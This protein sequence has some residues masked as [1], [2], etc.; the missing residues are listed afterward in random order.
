MA[1]LPGD[2]TALDGD[3]DLSIQLLGAF[4]V[5]VGP[6]TVVESE[7]RLRKAKSL[8]KLLALAPGQQLHR[9]EL[10]EALW[11]E[12]DPDSA[13]NNLHKAVYTVRRALEPNLPPATPSRYLHVRGDTLTLHPPGALSIDVAAFEQAAAEAVRRGD[14]GAFDAALRFY[15]GD[16]LPEDRYEDW[17]AGRREDLR[18]RHLALLLELARLREAQRETAAASEALRRVVTQEPAHEEAHLALMGVYARAGQRHQALRQYQQLQ[19]TLRSELDV[20]PSP[21]SQRLYQDILAGRLAPEVS[22]HDA[23]IPPLARRKA[24]VES[25]AVLI[26]RER[27]IAGVT[28]LLRRPDV[29]LLT[30]TGPGGVGKTGLAAHV[31]AKLQDDAPDGVYVVSLAA[32]ADPDLVPAAIGAALAV[33]EQGERTIAER[34]R[35]TLTTRRLILVLDNFEHLLPA[36][37]YIAELLEAAPGL[38]VLVTSRIP[39]RLRAEREYPVAPLG[40]PHQALLPGLEHL[41]QVHAIRLFVERAQAIKPDFVLD[42]ES[43]LAVAEICRRLDGLPL[44]IE[45][46]AARVRL[47]SPQ[48]MLARL[49]QRLPLLTGGARDSPQ[50]QRSLRDAI[51]WSYDLLSDADRRLFRRLAVFAGGTSLQSAEVVTDLD[52]DLD[53]FAGLDRLVEQN[54]LRQIAGTGDDLRLGMLETIREFGLEQLEAAGEGPATRTCHAQ[55]ML[56]LYAA[57]ETHLLARQFG[58]WHRWLQLLEM[59]HD[60]LRA[61]LTWLASCG[62]TETGL[63]VAGTASLFWYLSGHWR[64][65]LGWLERLLAGDGQAHPGARARALVG[66]GILAH[67]VGD[68]A[69]SLPA[70]EEALALSRQH[71]NWFDKGYALFWLGVVA[72]NRGDYPQA[73][74]WLQE[75]LQFGRAG[76]DPYAIAWVSHHLGAVAFG[77]GE[78]E[79]ARRLWSEALAGFRALGAPWAIAVTLGALGLLATVENEFGPA[80]AQL[81][82]ALA[83]Y[84]GLD[85]LPDLAGCLANLAALALRL[86]QPAAATRVLSAAEAL[87]EVLGDTFWQPWRTVHE[88][89]KA[90]LAADLERDAFTLAW[91]AGSALTRE[92]ALAEARAILDLPSTGALEARAQRSPS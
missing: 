81:A 12:M 65:G 88:Q 74:T 39:L 14:A 17:A 77:R 87:N 23:P 91:Q 41:M 59:E 70:L 21:A 61:A 42:H 5:A 62:D 28:A 24:R 51:A 20:D 15:A 40:L 6:R 71:G 1:E 52:G 7:W 16:L 38:Q 8:V 66:L 35:D 44:A 2:E 84:D 76:G 31:A 46:A 22:E 68:D 75:S 86:D 37:L 18:A 78:L 30:L 25:G 90:A 33:R 85:A 10:L 43:A 27:E 67:R 58:S 19:E 36:A 54:L 57:G 11:P 47:L 50:R 49:E 63:Q 60:N 32:L 79:D 72:Q 92:H 45:L 34:V 29:R 56:A 82:E 3:A 9:E 53:I 13:A 26:G 4:R 48:A 89:T 64:E 73:A 55:R 83:L 80:R 69:R